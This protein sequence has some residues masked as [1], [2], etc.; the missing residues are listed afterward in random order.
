M[1]PN[2]ENVL[3]YLQTLQDRNCE[4]LEKMDGVVKFC[5]DEWQRP[6][7]GGGRTRIM[8]NGGVFEQAGVGFSHV[9]GDRLPPA[10][11]TQRSELAGRHFQAMGVSI[12][13]HPRNP[14]VPT[15]HCNVRFFIAEKENGLKKFKL[16]TCL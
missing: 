1:A 2:I 6:E 14:F 10:A 3:S 16:Y 12:V 15:S 9:Y 11:T 8:Q 4:L 7:G 5:E 13:I